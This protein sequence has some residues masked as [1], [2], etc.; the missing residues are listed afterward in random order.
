V[1]R[2]VHAGFD[3]VACYINDLRMAYGA[4]AS[5]AHD[6]NGGTVVGVTFHR[7]QAPVAAAAAAKAGDDDEE[8]AAAASAAAALT[9]MSLEAPRTFNPGLA[10]AVAPVRA[11][12]SAV[13]GDESGELTS[14]TAFNKAD[15]LDQFARMGRGV[16][17][18]V[19][20]GYEA[21]TE[22]VNY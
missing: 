22:N 14:M 21:F 10:A 16:V 5:F 19:Y 9:A 4:L 7:H 2:P 20:D 17:E 11:P 1:S 3:P 8:D 15:L 12:G 18:R 13:E 6:P